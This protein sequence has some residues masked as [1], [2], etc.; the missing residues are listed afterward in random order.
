ME[1]C[2]KK[3]WIEKIRQIDK[4]LQVWKKKNLTT[5]AIIIILKCLAIPKIIHKIANIR[6]HIYRN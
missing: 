5:S 1:A 4:L 3:D 6:I 2:N